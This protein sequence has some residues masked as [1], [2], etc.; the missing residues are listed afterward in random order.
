MRIN[1]ALSAGPVAVSAVFYVEV[2][3]VAVIVVVAGTKNRGEIRTAVGAH[4]VKQPALAEREQAWFV[5]VYEL[6][7]VQLDRH[8]VER[9]AFAMLG[10]NPFAAYL[11]AGIAGALPYRFDAG[12][13]APAQR[14]TASAV[15]V[16]NFF[17][18]IPYEVK[19]RRRF[20]R[21]VSGKRENGEGL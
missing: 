10:Q 5:N 20:W 3:M 4:G 1:D 9:V 19:D 2:K 12:K 21:A 16:S 14:L 6:A 8:H 15:V 11:A 17:I 18:M 7:I 13:I